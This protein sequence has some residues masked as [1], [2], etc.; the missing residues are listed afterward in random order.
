MSGNRESETGAAKF[1]G[2]RC[3]R[4][5]EGLKQVVELVA[6]DTDPGIRDLEP[7]QDACIVAA[8]AICAYDDAAIICKFDRITQKIDQYLA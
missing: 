6:F 8:D 3:I 5:L 2:D 4:L 1:P 7:E